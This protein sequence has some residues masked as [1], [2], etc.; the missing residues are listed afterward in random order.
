VLRLIEEHERGREGQRERIG[1]QQPLWQGLSSAFSPD[2]LAWT[3]LLVP[4]YSIS[5]SGAP[6]LW[7][8][9]F[10]RGTK[11]TSSICVLTWGLEFISK[12]D[13]SINNYKTMWLGPRRGIEGVM[14]KQ[15]RENSIWL[16]WNERLTGKALNRTLKLWIKHCKDKNITSKGI[17]TE[18]SRGES[19]RWVREV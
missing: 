9:W 5:I 7:W 10:P 19:R 17:G 8:G 11:D 6:I 18:R 13:K 4:L 2:P 15:G 1:E 3:Q 12:A 14:W 16:G